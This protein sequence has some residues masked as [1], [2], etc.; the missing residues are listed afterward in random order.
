[1][2]LKEI[3]NEQYLLQMIF[4]KNQNI[5]LLTQECE[6]LMSEVHELRNGGENADSKE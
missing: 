2:N 3:S 6:K 1:M 4:E 5:T